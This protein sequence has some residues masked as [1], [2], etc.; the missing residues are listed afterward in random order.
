MDGLYSVI[1]QSFFCNAKHLWEG[2]MKLI[3]IIG[4]KPLSFKLDNILQLKYM[5]LLSHELLRM[6]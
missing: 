5:Y 6:I 4:L 3:H 2:E 1:Y